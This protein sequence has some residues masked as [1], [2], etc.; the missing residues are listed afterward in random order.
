MLNVNFSLSG[1]K[2]PLQSLTIPPFL[3]ALAQVVTELLESHGVIV[4]VEKECVVLMFPEETIEEELFPRISGSLCRF[5]VTLP[6]GYQFK[7]IYNVTTNPHSSI[8]FDAN[9]IAKDFWDK[10]P[11]LYRQIGSGH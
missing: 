2:S 4:Q 11:G 5:I 9:D 10:N 1:H 7:H 8:A 3:P 6:D